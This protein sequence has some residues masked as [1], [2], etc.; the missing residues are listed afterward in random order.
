METYVEEEEG[1][2]LRTFL[3]YLWGMETW[4]GINVIWP[5]PPVLILPMRNGNRRMEKMRKVRVMVL[6][7]PMRNGNNNCKWKISFKL[8]FLSYLWGMETPP[9]IQN[10]QT[11]LY[12]SY[13]TYEEWKLALS[14]TSKL[15]T[16][17]S[18]PT[19]EEW[20]LFPAS[21]FVSCSISS[22]PTYEEWKPKRC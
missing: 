16:Q 9:R 11:H 14:C 15:W 21:C 5:S 8:R 1:I 13:P 4:F 2:R 10:H 3:S 18:Y 7:L 19:Y 17:R 12:S 22:Y 6:I 20:K